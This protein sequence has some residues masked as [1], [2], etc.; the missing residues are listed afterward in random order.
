MF[1]DPELAS[2][3]LEGHANA[4]LGDIVFDHLRGVVIPNPEARAVDPPFLV[5]FWLRDF[6]LSVS[7]C[8]ITAYQDA[9]SAIA[10]AQEIVEQERSSH[11]ADWEVYCLRVTQASER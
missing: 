9:G 2:R 8:T 7:S 6:E 11:G 1:S 5:V 4:W 3:Y 10:A